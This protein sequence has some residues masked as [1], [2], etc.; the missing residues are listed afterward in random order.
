MGKITLYFALLGSIFCTQIVAAQEEQVAPKYLT[1]VGW[2]RGINPQLNTLYL[3]ART[4]SLWPLGQNFSLGMSFNGYIN[5]NSNST[6]FEGLF[7]IGLGPEYRLPFFDSY[8]HFAV[9]PLVGYLWASPINSWSFLPIDLHV[10]YPFW[11]NS[12]SSFNLGAGWMSTPLVSNSAIINPSFWR[13][14]IIYKF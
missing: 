12:S 7:A 5:L 14:N 9:H 10:H 1:A 2:A 6:G 4:E 13:V 3:G 11:Q 8:L